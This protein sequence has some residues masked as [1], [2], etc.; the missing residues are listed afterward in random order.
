MLSLPAY[1][2]SALLLP[3]APPARTSTCTLSASCAPLLSRRQFLAASCASSLGA[4][5]LPAKAVFAADN[6]DKLVERLLQVREKLVA[7]EA[8]LDAGIFDA[9]RNT[10]KLALAPL[11]LKGYLGDSVKARA[12]A[13]GEDNALGTSLKA[14]RQALLVALSGVDTYCY[15]RQTGR[16]SSREAG[17]KARQLLETAITTLDEVISVSRD[18]G[19]QLASAS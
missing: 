13:L 18:A 8:D 6:E 15:E 2:S 17:E 1:F 16:S 19:R 9:V 3:T 4:T 7:A 10:I 14:K 5:L 11:T 12:A